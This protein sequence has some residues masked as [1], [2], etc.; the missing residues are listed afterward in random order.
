MALLGF[1]QRPSDGIAHVVL[2]AA[3]LRH[4]GHR[5]GAWVNEGQ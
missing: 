2:A 3:S 4:A 5:A 1:G